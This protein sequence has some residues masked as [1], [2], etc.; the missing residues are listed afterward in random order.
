MKIS[1]MFDIPGAQTREHALA[2]LDRVVMGQVRITAGR[3]K[4]EVLPEK[5]LD[6][7]A[8]IGDDGTHYGTCSE[9][10]DG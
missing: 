6:G 3:L 2:V 4:A 5:E 7:I 1:V 9:G 8:L 10:D